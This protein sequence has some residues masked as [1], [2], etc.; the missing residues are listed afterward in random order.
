MVWKDNTD[1][2]REVIDW[3]RE[4]KRRT[5]KDLESLDP[6]SREG[7]SFARAYDIVRY[8]AIIA[9]ANNGSEQKRWMDLPLPMID[10]VN[11]YVM[12]E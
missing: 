3:Q 10:E 1:Y 9:I 5:G 6:D 4:F 7:A 11:F 12:G 2:A 8:P